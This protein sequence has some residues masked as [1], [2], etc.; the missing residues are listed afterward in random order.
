[1]TELPKNLLNSEIGKFSSSLMISFKSL[2]SLNLGYL[3]MNF[4]HRKV[5]LPLSSAHSFPTRRSSDLK[6]VV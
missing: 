1:M 3:S 4:F 2:H 6:S 5:C